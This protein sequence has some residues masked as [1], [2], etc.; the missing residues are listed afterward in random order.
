MLF[1]YS[2]YNLV[3]KIHINNEEPSINSDLLLYFLIKTAYKNQKKGA[4][5]HPSSYYLCYRNF[6]IT[7]SEH[8]T[9]RMS[10]YP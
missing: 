10:C 6:E 4:L 7:S 8:Q 2:S 9:K 5:L 1:V 3:A